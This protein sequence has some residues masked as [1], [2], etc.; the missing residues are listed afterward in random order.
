[1]KRLDIGKQP[2]EVRRASRYRRVVRCPCA[3]GAVPLP[4]VNKGIECHTDRIVGSDEGP[5][6]LVFS[7]PGPRTDRRNTLRFSNDLPARNHGTVARRQRVAVQEE[8]REKRRRLMQPGPRD[9]LQVTI[10]SLRYL[11]PPVEHR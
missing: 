5:E 2:F 3:G 4:V 10:T 6:I 7:R 11:W 8:C 1:M 9:W